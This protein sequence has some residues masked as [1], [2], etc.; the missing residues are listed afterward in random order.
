VNVY[1]Y[2][3][4]WSVDSIVKYRILRFCMVLYGEEVEGEG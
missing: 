1:A 4:G 3:Y 2:V